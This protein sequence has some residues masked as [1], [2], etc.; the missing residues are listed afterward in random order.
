MI[1]HLNLSECHCASTS[2]SAHDFLV[3]CGDLTRRPTRA[4]VRTRCDRRQARATAAQ[5]TSQRS[6]LRWWFILRTSGI[7]RWWAGCQLCNASGVSSTFAAREY[8]SPT[9]RCQSRWSW[10]SRRD[11]VF[12]FSRQMQSTWQAVKQGHRCISSTSPERA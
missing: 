12:S 1:R 9:T 8:P 10:Q 6:E 5:L 4:H 11:Q 2:G 7:E 3:D